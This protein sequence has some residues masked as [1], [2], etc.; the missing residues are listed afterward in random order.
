M[1][2]ADDNSLLII[3]IED[4]IAYEKLDEIIAVDHIDVFFVAPGDFAASMGHKGNID[5][6]DVIETMNDAYHR[7]VASG[8]TAGAICG[9]GNAERFLDLG[10]KLLFTNTPEWIN[11]GAA[12]FMEIVNGHSG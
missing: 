12:S 6:P 1:D 4:I 10:V 5:H 9:K 7:I 3:L 11:E 8:R 2:V